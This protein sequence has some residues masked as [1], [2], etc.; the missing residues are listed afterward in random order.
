MSE[1]NE[2]EKNESLE[3]KKEEE[4]EEEK[5]LK[6]KMKFLGDAVYESWRKDCDRVFEL[7]KN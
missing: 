3:N 7:K 2:K 6:E 1:E 5:S 4:K